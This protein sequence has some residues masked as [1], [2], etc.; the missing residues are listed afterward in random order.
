MEPVYMIMGQACGTA[1]CL[2]IDEGTDV[3]KVEY[4]KLKERLLADKQLIEW[5]GP[6]KT[7]T[8]M[9]RSTDLPGVVV[10]DTKARLTGDWKTGSYP[11]IDGKYQHDLNEGKGHKEARFELRVPTDGKYE[12]RFA[13]VANN[14]RASNVP[15]TVESAGRK[16]TVKVNEKKP[17][18]GDKSFASLGV[19]ECRSDTPVVVTVT[20]EGTDGYV[21]IDAVQAVA[22][23]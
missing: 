8:P 22:V 16:K 23:K 10:D 19:F 14:N 9:V 17:P 21:V 2:A 11:G 13:Y 18:A 12:V 15:V 1:A 7:I 20:N 3:Q 6:T 5:T 4:A